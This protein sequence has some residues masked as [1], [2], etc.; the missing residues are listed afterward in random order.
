MEGSVD[1]GAEL[2]ALRRRAY[3]ADAD[4][5]HDPVALARLAELEDLARL[6]R[7]PGREPAARSE[8]TGRAARTT[9]TARSRHPTPPL[10]PRPRSPP[11]PGPRRIDHRRPCALRSRRGAAAS[12]PVARR[13]RRRHGGAR[14]RAR[15]CG[16][17]RA[18]AR[19]RRSPTRGSRPRSPCRVVEDRAW[20]SS[21]EGYLEF[22]DSLRDDVLAGAGT[23]PSWPAASSA[24]GC[25]RT[26]G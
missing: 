18:G 23:E 17:G 14:R 16:L 13:A 5:E 2:A 7:D 19:P 21:Q 12:A 10:A 15:R 8:S 9:R 22:L 3:A 4:I 25:A 1:G 11:R 26:A 24:T 20:A 6:A